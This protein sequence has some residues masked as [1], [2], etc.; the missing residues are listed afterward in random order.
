MIVPCEIKLLHDDDEEFFFFQGYASTFGNLDLGDDVVMP[1]AFIK[2]LSERQP[3]LLWQHDHSE[4]IGI[5]QEVKED[6]IGLF[7]DAKLPKSDT[8]VEGRVIPQIKVGSINSMSIGFRTIKS[9]FDTETD[10]RKIIEVKLFEISLVSIPMNTQAMITAFKGLELNGDY[11]FRNMGQVSKFLKG[12]GLS[13]KETDDIVFCLKEII[14]CKLKQEYA[15]PV[16]NQNNKDSQLPCNE[17]DRSRNKSDEDQDLLLKALQEL[18]QTCLDK[19]PQV[20][21]T[22]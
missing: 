7:V 3:K 12:K 20:E 11:A 1:G 17:E 22:L 13:N 9:E 15:T 8:F 14:S 5:F 16:E 6:N 19:L 21:K 2:S 18:K 10:I 4:P